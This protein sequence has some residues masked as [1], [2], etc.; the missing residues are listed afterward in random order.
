MH[1]SISTLAD[2]PELADA[3]WSMRDSWP[4]FAKKDP[5]AS[6]YYNSHVINRL[7]DFVL[8]GQDETGAIVAKAHSI[9]LHL[10]ELGALPP[11]GWDGAIRRG[12]TTLLSGA[13]PNIVSALEISVAAR[14]Q[15][16]GL[17]STMLAALRE[18]AARRGFD[19]LVAPL[20]PNG[21]TDVS[22]P[23][24]TYA[25]RT[26][27]DGLPTDPW[28]RVHVRAGGRIDSI[29]PRSMVIPGTVDEWREW[30][31]LPFDRTGPIDVP[32]ALAPV[33][34]DLEHG[35]AVYAEPNI[36]IR[37]SCRP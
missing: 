31:G 13:R 24:T 1:L 5:L 17:S 9:P 16:R 15:G 32:G 12:V 22:E 28:L 35:T 37:H 18:N 26:R 11:D 21:K 19:E 4:V 6:M 34:C 27:P 7:A 10:P 23:M 20:R 29:A 25:R 8:V 2:R 14:A 36:W 3:M 30:T 33:W